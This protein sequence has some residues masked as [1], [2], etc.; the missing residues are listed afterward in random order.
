MNA[1]M[2]LLLSADLVAAKHPSAIRAPVS[3]PAAGEPFLADVILLQCCIDS[4][5]TPSFQVLL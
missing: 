2:G 3:A 4:K 1:S 5:P